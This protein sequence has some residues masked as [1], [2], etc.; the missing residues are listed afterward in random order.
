MHSK[1][2]IAHTDFT[3]QISEITEVHHGEKVLQTTLDPPDVKD[4]IAKGPTETFL[5]LLSGSPLPANIFLSTLDEIL[6]ERLPIVHKIW[7]TS[8]GYQLREILHRT[9]ESYGSLV[10]DG[11]RHQTPGGCFLSV[12]KNSY[13]IF[14]PAQREF[15]GF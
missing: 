6:G 3:Y 1:H 12:S 2:L 10:K 5:S 8:T 4:L 15:L 9:V 13:D 7:F 14:S 11:S